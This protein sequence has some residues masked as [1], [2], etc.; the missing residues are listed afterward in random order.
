MSAAP[1]TRGASLAAALVSALLALGSAGALSG[2]GLKG[3]FQ[4][5]IVSDPRRLRSVVQGL[6]EVFFGIRVHG[7]SKAWS[8]GYGAAGRREVSGVSGSLM[9]EYRK[10]SWR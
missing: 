7:E 5:P 9:L 4:L 10:F 1:A 8:G 3:G 2:C 6:E